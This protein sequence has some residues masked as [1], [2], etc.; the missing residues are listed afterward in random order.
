MLTRDLGLA[1]RGA[2]RG[3]DP[4]LDRVDAIERQRAAD[5]HL[6]LDEQLVAGRPHPHALDRHHAGHAGRRCAR[7]L[8]RSAGRRG[9]G[10]RVDG[11]AAEPPAG[12]ADEHRDDDGG[13]R[14]RPRVAERDARRGRP[15]PRSTTTC[16]SRNAARR[17]PAPRS[18]SRLRRG[19][20]GGR[21]RNRPRSS[22]D[23]AERPDRRL[24]GMTAAAE[25][26]VPRLPDHDAGE[27]EQQRG[28]R[29][30][31]DALDLAVAVVVLLVGGLAGDAHGEIGHHGGGEVEQRMRRLRQHRE[32]AGGQPDHALGDRQ[33][34]GGK[35]RGER[36]ALLGV[37]FLLAGLL[38]GGRAVA[39]TATAVNEN[40]RSVSL[41][42]PIFSAMR[43]PMSS[44]SS[45][46]T[47]ARRFSVAPMMDWAN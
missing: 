41:V 19:R 11:A 14:I 5:R 21:G 38:H 27:Q 35:N 16:R 26:P 37:L 43:L 44:N 20:A 46:S 2:H 45:P 31:G 32:R 30:R 6:E 18:R 17:L 13:G 9:V 29:Q 12:D 42:S 22:R 33:P 7:T 4:L 34:G 8:S 24:D 28:L 36:D 39:P 25:Q 47:T 15:A 23:H 10:Q 40:A 3:F 1:D